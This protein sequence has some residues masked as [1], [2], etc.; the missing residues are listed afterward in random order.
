MD[1]YKISL[2]LAC[3]L[4]LLGS[5]SADAQT[6]TRIGYVNLDAVIGAS[7]AAKA[8]ESQWLAESQVFQTELNGMA[9]ELD[10]LNADY[11]QKSST[12]TPQ[13]RIERE[14]LIQQKDLLLSQRNQDLT[15]QANERQTELVSPVYEEVGAVVEAIRTEGNYA[16]IFDSSGQS[17]IAAD[18]ALDLTD[19][20]IARLQ[21]PKPDSTRGGVDSSGA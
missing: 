9:A 19:T 18:P 8:A 14:Q 10:S 12:M 15:A 7:P 6:P 13:A 5:G 11:A 20:V 3:S 16:V 4:L 17:I 1:R 21:A 2:A